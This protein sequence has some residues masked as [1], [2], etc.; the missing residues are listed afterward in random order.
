MS[1]SVL[2][3]VLLSHEGSSEVLFVD[4]STMAVYM[5][6]GVLAPTEKT[7][8]VLEDIAAQDEASMPYV[9]HRQIREVMEAEKDVFARNSD[10]AFRRI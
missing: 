8:L 3:P 5:P 2:L 1:V 6:S 7:Q 10:H 9:P 4:F